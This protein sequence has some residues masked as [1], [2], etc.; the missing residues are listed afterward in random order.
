MTTTLC[1]T[2]DEA[3]ALATVM[4]TLADEKLRD[5]R[6]GQTVD[7]TILSLRRAQ[8]HFEEL[9]ADLRASASA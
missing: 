3:L 9:H 2:P 8:H 1:K 6:E 7:E 5:L 4:R